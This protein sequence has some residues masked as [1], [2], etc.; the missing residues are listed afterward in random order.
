LV[1]NQWIV[2]P[3]QRTKLLVTVQN[4]TNKSITVTL[5]LGA[6]IASIKGEP[7]KVKLKPKER[8]EVG[9]P[10][11]VKSFADW[12]VKTVFVKGAWDTGQG[13]REAKNKAVW[14]RPLVVGRNAQVRCLT[15]A[16]TSHT[17]TIT[18]VNEPTTPFGDVSWHHPAKEVPGET[19]KDVEIVISGLPA[20]KPITL[21]VGD[22]R[23]GERKQ[24]RL[25]LPFSL[26]P[27]PC[28]M[29]LVVRWK[30]SAGNHERTANLSATLLPRD[31]PKTFPDQVATL[32]IA[33]AEAV[34]GL[35]LSVDLT[36]SVRSETFVVRLPDGT[37]L[38][39]HTEKV[40]GSAGASPSL[41]VHFVILP[42][43]QSL[44]VDIGSEQDEHVLVKGFSHRE[45]WADGRT[46]RWLPGEGRG[47]VLRLKCKPNQ[48][49]RLLLHGQAFWANSVSVFANGQKIGDFPI[50]QGTQTLV[51]PLP[52]VPQET[53]DV[54]LV[55]QQTHIPTE[56]S[57]NSTDKRVCNFALDW[58]AL[59][60]DLSGQPL[61]L[62]LC[63]ARKEELPTPF[64]VEQSNGF[65]R[66]D[67]GALVMEWREEAGGTVTKFLSRDTGRDY[68]AQSFG[69]GIGVFG[70]FDP[71]R[72]ATDT[73]HFIVDEFVWQHEGKGSVRIVEINPVWVTVEVKALRRNLEGTWGKGHGTGAANLK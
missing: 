3:G 36:A 51:I 38:P 63:Q 68:A 24:I 54:Q 61:L 22:L 40:K 47:T 9:L 58:L 25:P 30:Y 73:A 66:V 57:P 43:L 41:R 21:K 48:P 1:T 23:E 69:V 70:K 14:L 13:T 27:A 60:P 42:P 33:D 32:V 50:R 20:G 71:E 72:F 5:G 55:F 45:T 46:I 67:N 65:V 31:L 19:A 12:G 17:P 2:F 11:E 62:A 16:V 28:P 52:P 6:V 4:L 35:P 8:K 39:T 53:V 18:L 44:R 56:K 7:V 37:P 34:Q 26:S 64:H 10:V 15:T 59:E 29:S 49:H